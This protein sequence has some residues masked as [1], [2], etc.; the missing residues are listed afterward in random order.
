MVENEYPLRVVQYG[1][2]PDTGGP[3]TYRG[4]LSLVREFELLADAAILTV[5][6][7]K[8]TF[9]PYGLAGGDPGAPSWNVLIRDGVERVLP[10][11]LTRP[12]IMRKGDRFRHIMAGGGGY[13][14]AFERDPELILK[15]VIAGKVSRER[16]RDD[17]GVVITGEGRR[18]RLDREATRALRARGGSAGS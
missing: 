9:P 3:G 17:Y 6:S 5:R 7:D 2:V 14:P 16:A 1:L 13:G 8:R 15:D 18:L 10:V 4:G 12:E 11:L